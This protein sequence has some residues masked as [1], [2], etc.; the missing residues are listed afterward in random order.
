VA[1][2]VGG[3]LPEAGVW[4][5]EEDSSLLASHKAKDLVGVKLGDWGDVCPEDARE[6][7]RSI[8]QGYRIIRSYRVGEDNAKVWLITEAD[9]SS[10]CILLPSEY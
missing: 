5:S 10:S 7:E 9:R 1:R 4:D 2:Q 8:G 6:N 3:D